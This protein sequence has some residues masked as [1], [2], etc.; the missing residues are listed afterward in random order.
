MTLDPIIIRL[1][2]HT[3]HTIYS[4]DCKNK[5][6]FL[7]KKLLIVDD[8]SQIYFL[9]LSITIECVVVLV[10]VFS[11]AATSD[12]VG[13]EAV[14]FMSFVIRDCTFFEVF[15]YLRVYEWCR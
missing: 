14:T 7:T 11:E 3:I 12:G 9:S 4:C 13:G 1:I 8:I 15:V 2:T 10:I 6:K 5:L